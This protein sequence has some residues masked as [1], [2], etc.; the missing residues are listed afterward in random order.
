MAGIFVSYRSSDE[1]YGA[2]A[3]DMKLVE[4]FG[5]DL[6]FRDNRSIPAGTDFPPFLWS[7][8]ETCQVLI[9]VIGPRWLEPDTHGRR[10]IDDPADYVRREIAY[11]LRRGIP[12]IPV[13]LDQT[14][15]PVAKDLPPDVRRLVDRQYR[16]VQRR[17]VGPDLAA[18]LTEIETWVQPRQAEAPDG[19]APGGDVINPRIGSI[20][21]PTAFGRGSTGAVFHGNVQDGRKP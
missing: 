12:V 19:P 17:S 21:A 6:V 3:I 5:A 9:A 16:R 18:L 8:L 2:I 15:L 1:E 7:W 10:R 20:Q 13:L 4:H 11:G 14:A